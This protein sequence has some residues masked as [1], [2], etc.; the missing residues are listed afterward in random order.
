MIFSLKGE[1]GWLQLL[2][3]KK[4]RALHAKEKQQIRER[5]G[6]RIAL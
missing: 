3:K 2:R 4:I 6:T 1:T 5:A